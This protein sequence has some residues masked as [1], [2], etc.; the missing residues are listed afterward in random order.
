[1]NRDQERLMDY[2]P[3][4]G[5]PK[6]YPSHAAQWRDYHGHATAWL[7]NPWTGLQRD[8]RDVGSDVKGLLILPPGAALSAVR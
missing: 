4:T 1:M 8:A 2:D 6:P 7:Y 3:A 5:Q